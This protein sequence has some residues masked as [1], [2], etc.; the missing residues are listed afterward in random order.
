MSTTRGE[1]TERSR[2]LQR[3][4][5]SGKFDSEKLWEVLVLPKS[6]LTVEDAKERIR[7]FGSKDINLS[8]D[9][10]AERKRWRDLR[11]TLRVK[12]SVV[13]NNI[14]EFLESRVLAPNLLDSK[15][16]V[17]RP[18]LGKDKRLRVF[19]PENALLEWDVFDQN[20]R[21]FKQ[22]PSTNGEYDDPW[23]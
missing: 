5:Y 22:R 19:P 18:S 9:E 3:K 4:D 12:S 20:V 1:P 2:K 7:L 13:I 16:N 21:Q 14:E 17:S 10:E 11:E 23:F 15:K 6:K 8:D